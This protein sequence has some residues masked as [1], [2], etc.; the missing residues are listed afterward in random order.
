MRTR[1]PAIRHPIG[2]TRRTPG[3]TARGVTDDRPPP[4]V[5]AGLSGCGGCPGLGMRVARSS[6]VRMNRAGRVG[7]LFAPSTTR[8]PSK[9]TRP[10]AVA[11]RCFR[12]LVLTAK[13]GAV[14]VDG[15]HQGSDGRAGDVEADLVSDAE[16]VPDRAGAGGVD[17]LE[18][19]GTG[20]GHRQDP[21]PGAGES[22]GADGLVLHPGR[23]VGVLGVGCL[24]VTRRLD[25]QGRRHGGAV[26]TRC[27]APPR[28]PTPSPRR[29]EC[30][31]LRRPPPRIGEG[32]SSWWSQGDSNP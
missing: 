24:Q 23:R 26:G 5:G 8:A 12:V 3:T 28:R 11:S 29:S 6:S 13:P 10:S 14:A 7:W 9:V 21:A 19:L 15:R 22:V 18:V 17:D 25:E 20:E 16:V 27:A 32:P 1:L 4:N 2:A 31:E 30:R